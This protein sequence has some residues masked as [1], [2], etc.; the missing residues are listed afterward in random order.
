MRVGPEEFEGGS[1]RYGTL[2]IELGSEEKKVTESR[3]KDWR[4][5]F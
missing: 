1:R 2:V 4:H 3:K 5:A